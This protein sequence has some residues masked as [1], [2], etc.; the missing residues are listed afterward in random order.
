MAYGPP[1]GFGLRRPPPAPAPGVWVEDE[2][3][4][5]LPVQREVLVPAACPGDE[6]RE[7]ERLSPHRPRQPSFQPEM[8]TR[9]HIFRLPSREP[10]P[11]GVIRKLPGR[12]DGLPSPSA[13]PLR[14]S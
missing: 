10:A 2:I 11:G 13:A 5:D 3:E 8:V 6:P 7:S 12:S 4:C 1:G 14:P 9:N